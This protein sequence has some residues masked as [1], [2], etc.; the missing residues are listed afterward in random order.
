MRG[1][2]RVGPAERR[3]EGRK[4]MAASWRRFLIKASSKFRPVMP[5]RVYRTL[6]GWGRLGYLPRYERPRTLN[7]KVTWWLRHH[8][9]PRLT[10]RA[11][12][13]SVREYVASVT[14]WVR[15]PEVYAVAD[16]A[17]S[18]PFDVLPDVSVLKANHG[19]KQTMVLRRPFDVEAARAAGAEWLSQRLGASG[20]ERHYLGI[21]PRLYAEQY[22]GDA[23]GTLPR[24]FKVLVLNGRAQHISVSL[25]RATRPRVVLF[26]RDWQYLPVHLPE[27]LGGPPKV[28]EPERRPPRPERLGDLLQ[29]AELLAE[30]L[31][32]VRAD[33]YLVDGEI[34][35]GE[36][37]FS[38]GAGFVPYVPTSYDFEL[39]RRLDVG[40]PTDDRRRRA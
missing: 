20:W 14:P 6:Y 12:K 25:D 8:Q 21:R 36:L 18:F 16:D 3:S 31:P 34:Y 39:G 1:V 17:A 7:E 32:F 38:P 9:D 13:L 35:F 15:F 40:S 11:D 28:V 23:D 4:P 33:F 30:D 5:D 37:T 27:Y 2:D 10:Q 22:L 26:D 29:A 24:D 19:W